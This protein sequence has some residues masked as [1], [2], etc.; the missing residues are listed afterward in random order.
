MRHR[1]AA[2]ALGSLSDGS[3]AH[4][5][6]CLCYKGGAENRVGLRESRLQLS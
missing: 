3:A 5:Q 2:A 6:E 4:R 1:A